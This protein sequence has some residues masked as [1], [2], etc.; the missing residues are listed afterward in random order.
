MTASAKTIIYFFLSIII[1]YIFI[2]ANPVYN[3]LSFQ[4]LAFCIAATVWGIQVVAAFI[5][6]KEKRYTFLWCAGRVCFWGSA[7]LLL[8]VIINYYI[9]P[10]EGVQLQISAINVLLRVLLMAL[11]FSVFLKRL[12]LS[13]AWVVV[14]LLCLCIAV[15][16]QAR[17]V[18][19][20]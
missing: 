19:L 14:W 16:L 12:Q 13:Y 2:A 5:F 15:P 7:S 8:S 18:G 11:L 17:L 4:V 10:S 9:R 20:L 6:L 3:T 1:T